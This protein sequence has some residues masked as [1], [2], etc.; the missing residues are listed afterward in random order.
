MIGIKP[1]E[2]TVKLEAV[3][4]K[5]L[6]E[7]LEHSPDEAEYSTLVDHLEKVSSVQNEKK[8][9]VSMDQVVQTVGTLL[10]ILVIVAYEQ[11]HV[12]TSKGLAIATKTK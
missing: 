1:K 10:G 9:R 2:T 8:Q 3:K 5:I 4:N 12:W 6:D 7:M 11:K